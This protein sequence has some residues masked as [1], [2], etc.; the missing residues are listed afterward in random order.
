MQGLTEEQTE[1]LKKLPER[2]Q[3]IFWNLYA[4]P[5]DTAKWGGV[6]NLLTAMESPQC[7]VTIP[8]DEYVAGIVAASKE[9]MPS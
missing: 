5:M 8:L 7:K 4:N 1:R 6:D 3:E 2:L 9:K